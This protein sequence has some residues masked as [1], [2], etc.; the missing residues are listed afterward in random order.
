MIW[1][2]ESN[3]LASFF[4]R[5]EEESSWP[6]SRD[7][8][9]IGRRDRRDEVRPPERRYPRADRSVVKEVLKKV[10]P[11]LRALGFR[12]SGQNYRKHEGDF[13]FVI[14]F[15]GSSSGDKFYVTLGA[16]PVFVLAEGDV[17]LAAWK[18][19]E[20]FLRERVGEDWPWQ[21]SDELLAS[22]LAE[23]A[24]VQAAFFG[25]AQTLRSALATDSPDELI[26]KF[27]SGNGEAAAALGLAQAAARLG[28]IETARGLADRGLELAGDEAIILRAQ[29]RRVLQETGP[30]T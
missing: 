2:D 18:E 8:L 20:C 17:E 26:R 10:G 30:T 5:S 23:I 16:Q 21:M 14:N 25:N 7:G 9:F 1:H 6:A 24:A 4:W 11:S 27:S 28:H 15:Q 29:L 19:Y 3:S 12:G 13:F 22:L